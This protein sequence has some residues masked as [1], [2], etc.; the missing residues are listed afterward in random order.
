MS[1][2][3][4]SNP[5]TSLMMP[6]YSGCPS[7]TFPNVCAAFCKTKTFVS[8]SI[9]AIKGDTT[10][11]SKASC[12]FSSNSVSRGN[13]PTELKRICGTSEES[14]SMSGLRPP[15]CR[16]S[17]WTDSSCERFQM[18]PAAFST[19]AE[20]SQSNNFTKRATAPDCAMTKRFS[21]VSAN[22]N[23]VP[24][25]FSTAGAK[26]EALNTSSRRGMP[27]VLR[28]KA[29]RPSMEDKFQRAPAAF[30]C[31]MSLVG[32]SKQWTRPSAPP[33]SAIAMAPSSAALR[34]VRVIAATARSVSGRLT[35]RSCKSLGMP[36]SLR[37]SSLDLSST[38]RFSMAPAQ[39]RRVLSGLAGSKSSSNGAKAFMRLISGRCSSSRAK[40]PMHSAAFPAVT[41]SK[42][43]SSFTNCFI[44]PALDI[45]ALLS[46]STVRFL[47]APTA[48]LTCAWSSE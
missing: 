27:P 36:P 6:W 45:S 24:K 17:C 10:P 4:R 1:T 5:A 48:D 26:T 34:L 18:T 46:S 39:A 32:D 35:C 29:F 30:S 12:T 33:A 20:S 23:N 22:D 38:A 21:C 44:P 9:K 42:L 47:S 19:I 31:K 8:D 11:N 41:T 7:A 13:D 40:L 16:T 25:T 15:F 28:I 43:L 3:R 14:N 37:T 2:A